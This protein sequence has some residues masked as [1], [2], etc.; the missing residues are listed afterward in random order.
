M[1]ATGGVGGVGGAAARSKRMRPSPLASLASKNLMCWLRNSSRESA[2]SPLRSASSELAISIMNIG[3]CAG[4]A[5]TGVRYVPMGLAFAVGVTAGL[6]ALTRE[7]RLANIILGAVMA[8]AA[9]A[10]VATVRSVISE[11]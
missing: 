7:R 9:W 10:I 2:P 6:M 4:T 8:I 5:G 11:W 1:G 3:G